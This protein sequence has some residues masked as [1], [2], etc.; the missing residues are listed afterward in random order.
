M[1]DNDYYKTL[2]VSREASS[3]EI[4]KAYKKLARRYH[5]DVKPDDKD[6]AEKFKQLQEAY[7]VLGDSEKREQYD[8]Y[9]SAFGGA[10]RAPHGGTWTTDSGGAGPIDLSELFGGQIDLSDLLGGSFGRGGRGARQREPQTRKGQDI[11]Y[12]IEVPFQVAAIGGNHGIQLQRGASTERLNVKVPAGVENGSV[13]R[14]GGQGQPGQAGGPPGDLLL[15]VK[16]SPH[17]WFSREGKNV[18]IEAPVSPSEAALG[19]KIDVPTISEG[20]VTVKVPPGTS[21]GTKLRLRGKGVADPKSGLRG[22]QLVVVKIVV[23]GALDAESRR[24]YEQLGERTRV[25]PREGLWQ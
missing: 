10:G 19:A 20:D 15:T 23:P 1:A 16:V 3:D 25:S 5:P 9:G 12:E 21:S 13:I 2:G 24:L 17:P 7:A 18:I 14:L 4:K 22:D 8:R 6:A 11:A